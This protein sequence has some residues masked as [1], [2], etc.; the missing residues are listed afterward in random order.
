VSERLN[1][2][3]P[4]TFPNKMVRILLLAMEEVMGHNGLNA[5]LN[6]ASLQRLIGHLPPSNF[7]EGVTFEEIGRL[8][9][10]VEGIYGIRGGQR[11]IYQT[12]QVCFK[13]GVQDF[14]GVLGVADFVFRVLP[15][16]FRTR[17]ALEVQ[18]EIFNRY[19]DHQVLLGEDDQCYFWIMRHCGFCWKRLTQQPTCSLAIGL[20]DESL[21]WVSGGRRFRVEEISCIAKGDP[22]CVIEIDKFS[23]IK[24]E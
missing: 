24:W 7:E 5:V 16:T 9:A 19:S 2:Q 4:Y 13:Y 22:D 6:T 10:A 21:Y 3:R 23:N 17:I 18:A 11:L 20:L 8:F 12:G 1:S 14:G 15:L